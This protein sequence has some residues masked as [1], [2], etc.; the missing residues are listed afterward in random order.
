MKNLKTKIII[1]IIVIVV[2]GIILFTGHNLINLL[3]KMHGG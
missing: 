2:I 3:I 1:A